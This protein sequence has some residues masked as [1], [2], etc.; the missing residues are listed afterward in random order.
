MSSPSRHFPT[1][2]SVLLGM[3]SC[4]GPTTAPTLTQSFDPL[5]C[6][7]AKLDD[8]ETDIDCGGRCERTCALTERCQQDADCSSRACIVGQCQS[9]RC[10]G[11]CGYDCLERCNLGEK[12]SVHEDCSTGYCFGSSGLSCSQGNCY[13]E[14]SSCDF[15][16]ECR[17]RSCISGRC[18]LYRC[19]DGLRNGDESD[20][21]CGGACPRRCEATEDCR[22]ASDCSSLSCVGGKCAVPTCF[23]GVRNGTEQL[24]D[25]RGSCPIPCRDGAGCTS[26]QE[27]RSG[28]CAFVVGGRVCDPASCHDGLLGLGESDVDCGR[29]CA[30][31]CSTDQTC[32]LATDC[33]SGF[34]NGGRCGPPLTPN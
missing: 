27:C 7:N 14:Q 13:C 2:A 28:F 24:V 15:D 5:V 4:T 25:C 31:R 32:T 19:D 20:I 12:C 22:L 26:S 21:D 30:R 1:F 8:G 18:V 29:G 3:V 34:C 16:Q 33:A 10:I 11:T 6:E 23:D 9:S 17:S